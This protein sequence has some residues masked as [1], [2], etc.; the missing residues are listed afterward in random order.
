[1]A[2]VQQLAYA[3]QLAL[4][5]VFAAAAAPKLRHPGA[6]A[7]T[8]AG[9]RLLPR[10]L[11][12]AAAVALIIVESFLAVAFLSGWLRAIALPL[13][14]LVLVVFASAVIVNLRRGHRIECG[15]FGSGGERISARSVIRLFVLLAGVGLLAIGPASTT[16][17]TLAQ[18]GGSGAAYVVQVG[19]TTCFLLLAVTW[20]LNLPEVVSTLRQLRRD[21]PA[22]V[23]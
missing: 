12:P 16:I 7:R 21:P 9:Y 6:F 22:G 11:V 4:G 13:A 10:R 20:L 2:L 23:Q 15:C 8:V 5:V 19:G 1:M 17:T 18:R 14:M 3:L